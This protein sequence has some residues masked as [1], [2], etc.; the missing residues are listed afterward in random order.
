[1]PCKGCHG[2]AGRKKLANLC[3]QPCPAALTGRIEY[4]V[5][6]IDYSPADRVE[7]PVGR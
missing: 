4:V 5:F 2:D 3:D 7:G 6:A 1:M